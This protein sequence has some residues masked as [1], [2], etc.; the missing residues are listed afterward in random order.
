VVSGAAPI[1]AVAGTAAYD[2]AWEAPGVPRPHYAALLGHLQ[3][4]D[5]SALAADVSRRLTAAGVAFG[6]GAG[7][8][9]FEVDAVPR[10]VP[11]A[12]WR[13]LAAGLEQRVRALNAFL[14]DAY[15]ERRIVRAGLVR[16][17]VIDD[18]EGYEPELQ[19]RLPAIAPPAALAGLDVVRDPAGRL[20][21]LEDNLRAPSGFAYAAAARAAVDA[22]L[23]AVAGGLDD[24]AGPVREA[25][26][27]VLR[28]AAPAETAG[29]PFVVVLSDGP[30]A[31]S[32]WEHEQ[33]AAWVGAPVVTLGDLEAGDG[34]VWTR[35]AGGARRA[36]DVVYRRCDEDRL[37]DDDGRLTAPAE[38]LLE[39]WL[40]G[41]V[42]VVNA[43][44]TGLGDD[45]LVHAHVEAMVRF[46]L[47]EEPLVPSV[48]SADLGDAEALEALLD[49]LRGFV[50]KPRHGA[51]GEGV[52]VCAHA[53][54][55][56][57]R[58]LAAEL[59]ERPEAFIAQRTILLSEHPTVVTGRLQ[60]RHV[61]LRP[62]VASTPTGVRALP[63][64]LTRVALE[65]GAL[66]V[67]SHQ[68][69]GAKATWVQG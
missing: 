26:R 45:K 31:S 29:E 7:P 36:V 9:S 16:A 17:G 3:A 12:E 62:Y 30:Q 57:L 69:G 37:R 2:E 68:N 54:A 32:V 34:R 10:I 4:T 60:S 35:D 64:G 11:R 22:A 49:D 52:V 27:D 42:G 8:G 28:C 41:R 46:Y 40:A 58:R 15:G 33:V 66:V 44:G 50:V 5:L 43:F 1:P 6:E 67:N 55:D 20:F 24:L 61:D 48:P 25:L 39:P 14:A 53:E 51:G 18:A 19:G 47:G 21:V 13:A 59:R 23:P 65:K 56:D 63:G 38:L